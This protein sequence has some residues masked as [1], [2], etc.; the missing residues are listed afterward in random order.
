MNAMLEYL[1]RLAARLRG[2]LTGGDEPPWDPYAS[3]REPRRRD[4][5]GRRATAS[6]PEPE[7]DR[8][9]EAASRRNHR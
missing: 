6:V 2:R 9:V 5:G 7:P 8:F 1:R 4:P 3:V